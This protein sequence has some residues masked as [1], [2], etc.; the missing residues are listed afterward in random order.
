MNVDAAVTPACTAQATSA[1]A[2]IGKWRRMSWKSARSGLAKYNGS[3]ANLSIV[4]SHAS[5][6]ARLDSICVSR[7]AYG[8]IRSLID[9]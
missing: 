2:V 7:S 1:C 9:R 8:S 3:F 5:R 4:C 6:T